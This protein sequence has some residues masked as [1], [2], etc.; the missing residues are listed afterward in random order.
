MIFSNNQ[1]QNGTYKFKYRLLQT[2]NSEYI[3]DML[4]EVECH[5]T[6]NHWEILK[7]IEFYNKHC[8]TNGKINTVLYIWSFKFKRFPYGCIIIHKSLIFAHGGMRQLGVNYW[9]KYSLVVN[10]I[11]VISMLVITSI[12]KLLCTFLSS[13]KFYTNVLMEIPLLMGLIGNRLELV[14]KLDKSLY[15]LNK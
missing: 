5:K 14:L 9:G 13:I 1:E 3:V 8:N 10:L 2:N 6:Q 7:K 15:G 11:S 4:K 12:H